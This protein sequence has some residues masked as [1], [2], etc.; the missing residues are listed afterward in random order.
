MVSSAATA[1]AFLV[2]WSIVDA[3]SSQSSEKVA[4]IGT[5]GKLG[6]ETIV[7]LSSAGVGVKCLLRHDVS[8]I[9]PPASLDKATNS[10]EV[11]AYLQSLPGIE[12]V[13]GDVT[14]QESLQELFQDTSACLAV[15]GPVVPKPF[16]KSLFP[17]WLKESEPT[18][19]KQVNFEGVKNILKAMKASST[20]R[21]L[22]RITGKGEDPVRCCTA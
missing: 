13:Q 9:V 1:I 11:A 22:V 6:R 4:L 18:H 2:C 16:I 19:A 17:F 15:Y 10:A 20:C 12:M 5:T 7:Q 21:K 14:N 3:F 8:E